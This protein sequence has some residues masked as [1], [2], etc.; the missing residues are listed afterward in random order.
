MKSVSTWRK[1]TQHAAS[2]DPK[3]LAALG[4]GEL[5]IKRNHGERV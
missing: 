2:P 1:Y 4:P 3:G 5:D